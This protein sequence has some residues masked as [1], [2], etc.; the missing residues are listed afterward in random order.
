MGIDVLNGIAW[1]QEKEGLFVTGKLSPKLYGIKVRPIMK[2]FEGDIWRLCMPPNVT[3]YA[4]RFETGYEIGYAE[5]C[6]D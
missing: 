5:G 1:D 2:P 4:V 6:V 3:W